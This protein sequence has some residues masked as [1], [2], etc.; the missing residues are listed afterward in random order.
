MNTDQLVSIVIPCYK[1]GKFIGDALESI[2]KQTYGNW[3]VI[4]VD[5]CGPEDGTQAIVESFAKSHPD[6]RVEFIRHEKNKGVSAARNTAIHAAEGKYLAFLDPDDFWGSSYLWS[7]VKNLES[8]DNTAVSYTSARLVDQEGVITGEI[9]GPDIIDLPESL[10][11]QCLIIPSAV[12]AKRENVILCDGF[13]ETPELQHA[14]DW[15]LWL[16]MIEK[17]MGF[18]YTSSAICF[19]RQHQGASTFDPA[20]RRAREM[21]L[22]KKHSVLL[23]HYNRNLLRQIL[24]RVDHLEG[25]QKAFEGSLFFRLGRLLSSFFKKLMLRGKLR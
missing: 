5:D 4:A 17:E 9:F 24:Y 25:K 20:A 18:C 7:H 10:Y 11:F 3:E 16:R 6:H 1:M 23:A 2:G 13:D 12:M 8:H 19:W 15:D 21:A 22:R 14:E